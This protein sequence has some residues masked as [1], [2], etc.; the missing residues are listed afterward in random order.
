M[1]NLLIVLVFL[2]YGCSEQGSTK[3]MEQKDLDLQQEQLVTSTNEQ[4]ETIGTSGHELK[5]PCF[6]NPILNCYGASLGNFLNAYY[7]VGDFQT[8]Y[9]FIDNSSKRRYS[10]KLIEAWFR[11]INFGYEIDFTNRIAHSELHGEL[12]YIT[13]INNTRGRLFLPYIIENDSAKLKLFNL[14]NDIDAQLD[15]NLSAN[16]NELNTLA[17]ALEVKGFNVYHSSP[18]SI[19]IQLPEAIL[20]NSGEFELNA[21]GQGSLENLVEEIK[22]IKPIIKSVTCIGYADTDRVLKNAKYRDNLDLSALRAST[23]A[24]EL[25]NLRVVSG[26][27]VQVKGMGARFDGDATPDDKIGNRRVEIVLEF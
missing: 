3:I 20:F 7:L 24:T 22:E 16:I 15:K 4:N 26:E 9:A 5:D 14:D 6:K 13:T 18:T 25:I 10:K 12:V 21:K 23:V 19:R 11:Q 2:V 8:F 27:H 1:K 17:S